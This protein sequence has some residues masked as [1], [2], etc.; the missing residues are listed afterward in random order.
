MVKA[1]ALDLIL[2]EG[3]EYETGAREALVIT[4]VGTNS[5]NTT[6]PIH[7]VIDDKPLGDLLQ[8]LSPISKTNDRFWDL[9]PLGNLYYVCPP[10]TM[11]GVEGPSGLE[12][13]CK[14]RLL[15]LDVG[16]PMPTDLMA[17]FNAQA[18]HYYTFQYGYVDWSAGKT[19]AD[20]EE[21][22]V[23]SYTPKT[24]E[25]AIFNSR[26]MAK[27]TGWT[28]AVHEVALR[29][30][31]EGPPLD[32]LLEKTDVGGI[33][34]YNTPY[35]PTETTEHRGFTLCDFPVV[36]EGDHTIRFVMRNISGGNITIAAAS[37]NGP[38][39]AVIY[40]YQKTG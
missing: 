8:D 34:I 25:R 30:Y 7:L 32:F 10:E 24:I 15:K 18:T 4:E 36:V 22:D 23:I 6:T 13:R 2:E 39:V 20:D 1:F 12:I 11:I 31:V 19:F 27:L 38:Y 35:P 9:L 28:R 21:V 40:E 37:G 5:T 3:D 17:R 29:V 14:G 33:D 26:L 16:E